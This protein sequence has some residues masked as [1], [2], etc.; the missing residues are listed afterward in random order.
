MG[1]VYVFFALLLLVAFFVANKFVQKKLGSG[2]VAALS[3]SAVRNLISAL[4]MLTAYAFMFRGAPKFTG[5]SVVMAVML[6]A[7]VCAYTMV[8]FKIL[9]Y[10]SVSVFTVFLMLGGMILPYLY[11]VIWL[12]EGT[13]PFRIVGIVLMVISLFFP[14]LGMKTEDGTGAVRSK[15][16]RI[17]FAVLCFLVFTMNGFVSIISK[18]HAVR[19]SDQLSV[20]VSFVMLC[21][22][23]NGLLSLSA[24][25]VI[26]LAGHFRKGKKAREPEAPAEAETVPQTEAPAMT[27]ETLLPEAAEAAKAAEETEKRSSEHGFLALLRTAF[28]LIAL[29]AIFDG[30]SFFFQQLGAGSV[31]ASV[32]YPIMTGGSIVLSSLFGYLIFKEKLSKIA[33][34]GLAITFASTFLFLF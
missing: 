23:A 12:N 2:T 22:L 13:N 4:I 29:T 28:P 6:A 7:L 10:G 20:L 17:L 18:T 19:M 11:G 8:G 32:M 1:Y 25:G 21:G 16:G 26:K 27:E 5:F 9:D 31:P 3:Y 34:I 15:K 24:I 33:V 30:V 14:L